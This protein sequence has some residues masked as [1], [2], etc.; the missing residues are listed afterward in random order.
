M[1]YVDV[2]VVAALLYHGYQ[3]GSAPVNADLSYASGKVRVEVGK[4]VSPDPDADNY[5]KR[6]VIPK[7]LEV[8]RKTALRFIR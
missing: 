3:I 2:K 8:M 6:P 5:N 7:G 1:V 4:V